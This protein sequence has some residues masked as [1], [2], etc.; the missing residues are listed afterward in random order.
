MATANVLQSTWDMV[1]TDESATDRLANDL[2]AVLVPDDLLTLSGDLGAGKTTLARAVIRALAGDDQIEVPSPTFTFLQLY[3]LPRF[4]VVHAD[5]YRVT[6]LAELAELGW[7]EASEGAAVMVEWPDRA[8]A[9]IQA[10]RLDAALALAPDLGPTFRRVRLTGYGLWAN[11]LTRLRAT[12]V[13]I[14]ATGFAQARRVHLIGDASTRR[15]ERL[16]VEGASAI[17]MDSPPRPDGP[18][19]RGGRSYSALSHLAENVRPFVALARGLRERGFSAP[20]V[21]SADL[22]AGLLLLEDFGDEHVVAGDPPMPVEERYETAIDLLV[23]LHGQELPPTLP[24]APRLEHKL[25]PYDMGAFLIEVELLVDWYLPYRGAGPLTPVDREVFLML[26]QHALAEVVG[27]PTT[28]VLRDFHSPNLMWLDERQDV[29]RIGL[30]DFQDALIGP[31]AY[32]VASLLMDARVDVSQDLELK[33]LSRYAAGRTAAD[34]GFDLKPFVRQYVTLGAQRATKILGIFARLN[35]RDGKPEYLRHLP[36]VWSYL[37]RA[38]AHPS[39]A[40][41][42]KWYDA[43]VPAPV[44]AAVSEPATPPAA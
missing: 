12:R 23:T 26:W 15:Y 34:P 28:W 9:L 31:A 11:R 3:E 16:F 4:P 20:L 39:L 7:E 21:Q 10:D 33:L 36:R 32:D 17:L 14:D 6:T 19:V 35:K 18:P 38:L 27:A 8:A 40:E 25:P 5:L 30:L 13:L 1:L 22:E 43:H 41:L 2:S 42:A 37:A 24:V 44:T 29:E